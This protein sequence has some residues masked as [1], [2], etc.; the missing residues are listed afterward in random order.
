MRYP[1]LSVPG[2]VAGP[3]PLV[4]VAHGSSDPRAAASVATLLDLVRQRAETAGFPGLDVRAAYLGHAA[5]SLAQALA[6]LDG[7]PRDRDAVVLP[8][9][10]TAAY[11][12]K[13]DI[14][15]AL[16]EARTA[17]PR[18]AVS[19]GPPL[20]PHPLLLRA[21]ERRLGE[22]PH[23]GHRGV[24]FN[25]GETAVVL[26]AAG[27]SDSAAAGV[28]SGLASRWRAR[29]GWRAVLPAYASAATPTPADAVTA[30][31]RAGARHVLV[32]TYLLSPG[33]FADQ[34]R[35]DCLAAGAAGV[36][37]VLGAAPEIAEV[38]LGRYAE[39]LAQGGVAA[40]G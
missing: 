20:G 15:G 16:R 3:P 7:G 18:L 1:P 6:A 8:L 25:P 34:I 39:T 14:P 5:P 17:H 24:A 12:S 10:L 32:A 2:T 26:A 21:L 19:Y 22:I 11:H 28:I 13:A 29:R 4:A 23:D 35:R 38:V 27:S 31:R 30:L 9:L 36:S 40:A 37:P 33:I